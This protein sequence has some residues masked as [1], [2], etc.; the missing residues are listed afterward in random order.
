MDEIAHLQR[1]QRIELTDAKGLA[2]IEG[3]EEG[4]AE[5]VVR[6]AV[7]AAKI[8]VPYRFAAGPQIVAALGVVARSKFRPLDECVDILAVI[9]EGDRRV[10]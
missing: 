10:K 6:K 3:L 1:R 9:A 7:L 4:G 5:A 8:P 2:G